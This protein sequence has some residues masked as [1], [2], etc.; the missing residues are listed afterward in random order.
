[1]KRKSTSSRS[2]FFLKTK[3]QSINCKEKMVH[4]NCSCYM[5][6]YIIFLMY[7]TVWNTK[8]LE[9]RLDNSKI[10]VRVEC[11]K[12][13]PP[14]HVLNYMIKNWHDRNDDKFNMNWKEGW[15]YTI[16]FLEYFQEKDFVLYVFYITCFF[17]TLSPTLYMQLYFN[18][19]SYIIIIFHY[20]HVVF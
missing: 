5:R 9:T 2:T 16:H 6:M 14:L 11:D 19:Q 7:C 1:M 18:S 12:I 20:S 15:N 3:C 8:G 10:A 17:V 13:Q 4:T